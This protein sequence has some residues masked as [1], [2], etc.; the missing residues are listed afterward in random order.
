MLCVISVFG[1]E[2]SGIDAKTGRS[3][4]NGCRCLCEH[5]VAVFSDISSI[6]DS[7]RKVEYLASHD[8]FIGLLNRKQ[9]QDHLRQALSRAR[10]DKTKVALLF[11]DLDNFKTIKA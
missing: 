1:R 3:I 4:L 8:T 10:R 7:Q 11:I 9:L 2:R 6:K 5:Y